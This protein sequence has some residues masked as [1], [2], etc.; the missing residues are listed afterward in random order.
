MGYKC[1]KCGYVRQPT[2]TAP[3]YECPSCGV[4]YAKFEALQ[5]TKQSSPVGLAKESAVQ[6]NPSSKAGRATSAA[7]TRNDG[8]PRQRFRGLSGI[9]RAWL[10]GGGVLLILFTV[11]G[12]FY[13]HVKGPLKAALERGKRQD[14]MEPFFGI[15][16]HVTQN[17]LMERGYQCRQSEHR[18][19]NIYCEMDVPKGRQLYD[20]NAIKASVG[21]DRESGLVRS[22]SVT[23]EPKSSNGIVGIRDA[24]DKFH[25][26]KADIGDM[27]D[28]EREQTFLH[29]ERSDGSLLRLAYF[30][31]ERIGSP[32][33]IVVIAFPRD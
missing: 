26:R 13:P 18:K 7:S 19:N 10:I 29:W 3:D 8:A 20:H 32:A 12:V 28:Q 27:S 9:R 21:F 4:V 14:Q 33:H 1:Q 2:D 15:A 11:S 16:F 5:R 23:L 6:I 17:E 30:G 22:I 24:I 31:R 25:R